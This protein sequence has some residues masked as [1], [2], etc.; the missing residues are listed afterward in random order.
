MQLA[1]RHIAKYWLVYMYTFEQVCSLLYNYSTLQKIQFK[2]VIQPLKCKNTALRGQNKSFSLT[3]FFLI[4]SKI[5][6]SASSFNSYIVR[7]NNSQARMVKLPC[8]PWQLK[9]VGWLRLLCSI[10]VQIICS[11]RLELWILHTSYII[12]A[13]EDM[14]WLILYD[15]NFGAN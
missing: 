14:V 9:D 7:P 15:V 12:G 4:S 2:S 13:W 3:F 6:Y 1:K 11:V 8:R 10:D 5:R